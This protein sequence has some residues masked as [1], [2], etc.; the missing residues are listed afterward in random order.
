MSKITHWGGAVNS[1]G[2]ARMRAAA[3]NACQER[4]ERQGS[5]GTS[6]ETP[7]PPSLR[8]QQ[9]GS[10]I[11]IARLMSS[12]CLSPAISRSIVSAPQ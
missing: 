8:R 9:S 3:G 2:E 11:A 6:P 10:R 1:A 4:R 5:G 12:T 7:F